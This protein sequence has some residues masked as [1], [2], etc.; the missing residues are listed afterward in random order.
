MLKEQLILVAFGGNLP[1]EGEAPAQFIPRALE[2]LADLG[3]RIEHT[4][5]LYKTPCFPAGAG[6][7]Y[8]NGALSCSGNLT[9][10]QVLEVLH[11]VECDFGRARTSRWA[12]RTLDLDLIAVGSAV[13][14]DESTVRDWLELPLDTQ[15]LA[16][17]DQLI[18]PHPRIQDRAFVLVPLRDVAPD[19]RHPLLG[20]TV[21]EMY[22]S[23]PAE[24]VAEV[25][26]L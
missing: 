17:P 14:P 26:P 11:Q 10:D 20:K 2:Q 23:L 4:S 8:V 19:W 3:L 6:P 16:A 13:C 9:P 22:N 15:K 21:A 12:G 25:V 1:L 18:L 7:D 24:A 5:A